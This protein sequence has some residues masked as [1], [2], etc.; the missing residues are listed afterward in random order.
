MNFLITGGCG[1]IGSNY[2][3]YLFNNKKVKKIINLD[4]LY[5]CANIY[6]INENIRNNE[7]YKFIKGD[8]NEYD[9]IVKI[10]N[11]YKITHIVH[12]AAQS[13]VDNSFNNSLQYTY[14]NV[15]GTHTLLEA[16]KNTNKNIIMLHFSTDEVYGETENDEMD[17]SSLLCPTNPYSASKAAAE[18]Y[19]RAYIYSYKLKIIISRG[20]N[21]FGYNQYPEKLIPKFINLLREG[22]KCT[23]HGKGETIRNFIFIDD[24]CTAV[25][26]IIN[27]GTFGQVYNIGSDHSY[28]RSVIDVTKLLVKKIKNDDDYTKYIET[29]EDRP[30]NDKRYLI[31]NEKLKELGWVQKISFDKGID[32]L[33]EYNNDTQII[34]FKPLEENLNFDIFYNKLKKKYCYNIKIYS[35]NKEY[36]DFSFKFFNINDLFNYILSNNNYK[37]F[38]IIDDYNKFKINGLQKKITNF[39]NMILKNYISK[40]FN[41][42][43]ILDINFKEDCI[44]TLININ[45]LK[46]IL[47][48]TDISH[49]IN[50]KLLDYFLIIYNNYNNDNKYLRISNN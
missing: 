31:S 40:S 10:L 17:E 24:V 8:L 20:N 32:L 29:I 6:N 18:M 39:D 12:F 13:H 14:D 22:E 47:K 1:F 34:L 19:I 49:K 4:I 30:F 48:I 43:N 3:N 28:E 21:V 9:L 38:L 37:N 15:K 2:I 50:I 11:E 41:D 27:N 36:N 33:L 44:N 5:Y 26:Y 16:I 25:D 46:N 23:I 7:R 35:N 42:N 45:N